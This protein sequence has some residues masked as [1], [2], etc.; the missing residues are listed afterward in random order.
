MAVCIKEKNKA[1]KRNRQYSRSENIAVL[2]EWAREIS[3]RKGFD[4]ILIKT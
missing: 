2:I 1:R 3:L 4:A